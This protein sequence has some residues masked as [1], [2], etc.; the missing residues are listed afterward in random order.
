MAKN[1][2]YNPSIFF[3]LLM[4]KIHFG[5]KNQNGKPIFINEQSKTNFKAI[6]RKS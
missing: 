3:D 5:T 6:N 4:I 1:H 2:L